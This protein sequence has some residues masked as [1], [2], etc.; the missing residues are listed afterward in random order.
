MSFVLR[1]RR[2]LALALSLAAF[3]A[4]G[5]EGHAASGALTYESGGQTRSAFIVEHERL[6]R[7]LRPTVL[8]F[9]G[10]S[11][12]ALRTRRNIGLEDVIRSQGVV[13]VY[14][15]AKDGHWHLADSGKGEVQAIRDLIK[16]LVDERISDRRRIYLLGLGSGG[17]VAMRV[18]C[19][20][21]DDIAGVGALLVTMPPTLAATCRPSRPLPFF[22]LVGTADPLIPYA[23]GPANL[24]DY[25]LPL[26]SVE[27]TLAPFL[28]AASCSADKKTTTE[29]P[30]RDVKD[31]TRVT[32]D[33]FTDCRVPIELIRVVGGGHTLPGRW[34]GPAERDIPLGPHNN[35]IDSTKLIWDFFK[36]AGA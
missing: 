29:V 33:R 11:G 7:R 5:I 19:E 34:R 17:I 23:G 6:K 9:H 25:K 24:R 15:D 31:N 36:R 3:V 27:A 28:A 20:S 22:A 14:P 16:M 2:P 26:A 30:D 35:D 32:V 8:I 18:A 21:A 1:L 10:G 13:V 12:S 4:G